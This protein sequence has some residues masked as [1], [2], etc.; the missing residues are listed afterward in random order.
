MFDA[1]IWK[2]WRTSLKGFGTIRRKI[3]HCDFW[4]HQLMFHNENLAGKQWW[5]SSPSLCCLQGIRFPCVESLSK[6]VQPPLSPLSGQAEPF[7]AVQAP[8]EQWLLHIPISRTR[9]HGGRISWVMPM[10]SQQEAVWEAFQWFLLNWPLG[11]KTSFFPKPIFQTHVG[12][13]LEGPLRS[14]QKVFLEHNCLKLLLHQK[15]HY[16]YLFS[17]VISSP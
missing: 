16:T 11:H 1:W 17:W 12:V 3:R 7:H 4:L 10:G 15:L 8:A 2:I 5:C 9:G 14:G 13:S 6:L